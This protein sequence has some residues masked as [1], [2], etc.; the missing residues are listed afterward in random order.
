MERIGPRRRA[1]RR[2]RI[3]APIRPRASVEW[4]K[5]S[6]RLPS[7]CRNPTALTALDRAAT[8]RYT[9]LGYRVVPIDVSTVYTLNGSLGCL[10]NVMART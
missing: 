2:Y 3:I 10:V 1:G 9:P 6:Y 8:D 5:L 7:S 4:P